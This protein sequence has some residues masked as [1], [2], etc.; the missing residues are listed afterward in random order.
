ME[1]QM[2]A[3]LASLGLKSP[4]SPA[5]RQLARQSL[6]AMPSDPSA[7]LSPNSAM[8]HH[9]S[10]PR[11]NSDDAAS[12]TTTGGSTDPANLLAQQRAKLNANAAN[13][14]SA[15]GSLLNA[16]DA[17]A[18]LRSPLW[19]QVNSE[20]VAERPTSV[21][22]LSV[23]TNRSPSPDSRMNR[24]RPSSMI[25]DNGGSTNTSAEA[26]ATSSNNNNNRNFNLL[27]DAQLSPMLS[28]INW[29]N[30]MTTPLVSTFGAQATGNP[31]TSSFGNQQSSSKEW[32]TQN[33]QQQNSSQIVLDDAKKFRRNA[34][35]SDVGLEGAAGNANNAS[36]VQGILSG[37]Y[38]GS[39][40]TSGGNPANQ[41]Q[42]AQ[43]LN[44]PN[45][46]AAVAAQ[47]NWRNVNGLLGQQNSPLP[48]SANQYATANNQGNNGL[49]N[50]ANI[51][52]PDLSSQLATMQAAIAGMNVNN[53]QLAMANLLA[54][55]QQIQ[56][57]MQLQQNLN[58][59]NMA[60]ISPM[61]MMNNLQSQQML[62]PGE[63]II[64]CTNECATWH[65]DDSV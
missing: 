27:A 61:G 17:T 35:G 2:E 10:S 21:G 24:S 47:Q 42:T 16:Y 51:G 30:M 37:M 33:A 1:A 9:S 7:F 12:N 65:T 34:R 13:R 54:A 56:Q 22:G 5:V 58:L 62:S 40:R 6:G 50:T 28:G 55:Q 44:N 53:P 45:Q 19:S 18:S 48:N 11:L 14:I 15:P 8:L 46:A 25:S 59:M 60:G 57:Q 4:A 32:A 31:D 38:D 52:S 23:G 3:K 64:P 20:Q 39:R 49:P 29:A 36:G 63:Q 26:G 41:Q 43:A